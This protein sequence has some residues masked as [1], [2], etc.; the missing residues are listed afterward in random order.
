[1]DRVGCS[2]DRRPLTVVEELI[3]WTLAGLFKPSVGT[4][5][6]QVEAEGL[7]EYRVESA[8]REF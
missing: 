4:V 3:D 7:Q 5:G 1:V 8:G 6:V 2:V